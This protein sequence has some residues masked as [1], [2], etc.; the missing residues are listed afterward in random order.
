M[1]RRFAYEHHNFHL[2]PSMLFLKLAAL[3]MYCFLGALMDGSGS[4]MTGLL[5][6]KLIP[7][8]DQPWLVSDLSPSWYG[9]DTLS[10]STYKTRILAQSESVS[11]F[12]GRR[13]N[14]TTSHMLR[15]LIYDP[16]VEGECM[17]DIPRCDPAR[18]LSTCMRHHW[19]LLAQG[20]G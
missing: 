6:L 15:A 5:G 13:W 18:P 4:A 9:S 8:F 16:I 10:M 1:I 20:V 19:V 17:S 3:A 11:D 14:I 2:R 12:W 7:T